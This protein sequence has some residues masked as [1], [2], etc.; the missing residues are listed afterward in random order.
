MSWFIWKIE[1]GDVMIL[2]WLCVF[3]G[4]MNIESQ[5]D[6][7]IDEWVRSL[8]ICPF[9]TVHFLEREIDYTFRFSETLI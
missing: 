4:V 3:C 5:P 8:A 7:V 2:D 9:A 6:H 1:L